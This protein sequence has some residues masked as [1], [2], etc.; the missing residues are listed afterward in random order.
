MNKMGVVI[1]SSEKTR[2]TDLIKEGCIK[3]SRSTPKKRSVVNSINI[4]I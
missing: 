1:P 2:G 3:E 4:K